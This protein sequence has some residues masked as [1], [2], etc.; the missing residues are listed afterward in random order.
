VNRAFTLSSRGSYTGARL[1]FSAAT[2][3]VFRDFQCSIPWCCCPRQHQGI[4]GEAR[5]S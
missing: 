1:W 4:D 3:R 5:A 2:S